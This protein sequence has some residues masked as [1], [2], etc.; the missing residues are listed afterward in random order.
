MKK[1]NN[2]FVYLLFA[3]LFLY[4]NL[5]AQVD[6][7]PANN[8]V[9]AFLKQM[10]VQGILQNYSDIILPLSRKK[11]LEALEQIDAEKNKISE[12]DREYLE[13]LKEKLNYYEEKQASLIKSDSSISSSIFD[14]FPSDFSNN[15]FADSEKHL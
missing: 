12:T 4:G 2:L 5:T 9:Y 3:F 13:R 1:I 8:P 14:N 7:V 6:N 15:L 10:Q 11:V